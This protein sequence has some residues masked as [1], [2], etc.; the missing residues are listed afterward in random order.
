M[1]KKK[2]FPEENWNRKWKDIL[3]NSDG[4]INVEQLKLELSDFEELID[5][6]EE[7]T[8]RLTGQK[9]SYCTYAVDTIMNVAYETYEDGYGCPVCNSGMEEE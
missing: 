7:L 4:S 3:Q 8:C 9:L 1:S 6:M 5:R 2:N